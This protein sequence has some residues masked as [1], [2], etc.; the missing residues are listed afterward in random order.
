MGY[1]G[2]RGGDAAFKC[3]HYYT[4]IDQMW[5]GIGTGTIPPKSLFIA[6]TPLWALH[7][8]QWYGTKKPGGE[9]WLGETLPHAFL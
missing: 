4:Q 5:K 2:Q 3:G 9:G 6:D 7:W 1:R 8:C